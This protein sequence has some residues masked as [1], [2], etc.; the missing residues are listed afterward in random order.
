MR[1]EGACGCWPALEGF[2]QDAERPWPPG[3]AVRVCE[4]LLVERPDS[5][6][7]LWGGTCRFPERVGNL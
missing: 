6:R 4:G 2:P 1:L 3:G 5:L 7:K